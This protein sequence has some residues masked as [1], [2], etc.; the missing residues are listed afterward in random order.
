MAWWVKP[1]QHQEGYWT[2]CAISDEGG[3][4]KAGCEHHHENSDEA[5]AC[6]EAGMAVG[7]HTGFPVPLSEL[8]RTLYSTYRTYS[9]GVSLAT[10]FSIPPWDEL[11]IAIKAGWLVVAV[12]ADRTT[13]NKVLTEIQATLG[14]RG[15]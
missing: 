6:V 3:A 14:Y 4:F 8:A 12:I 9:K 2:L 5:K 10:G 15:T 1:L 11:P 13:R 7:Q